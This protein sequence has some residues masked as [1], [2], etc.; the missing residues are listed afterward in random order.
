MAQILAF[1]M[2]STYTRLQRVGAPRHS[3]SSSDEEPSL[4]K[5]RQL[6]SAPQPASFGS[7]MTDSVSELAPEQI[8]TIRPS[9]P[10]PSSAEFELTHDRA[11]PLPF[12]I[13]LVIRGK[14]HACRYVGHGKSKVV[15]KLTDSSMVLKL[16]ANEDKEPYVSQQ[17]SS[18]CRAVQPELKICPAIYAIGRCQQ[19]D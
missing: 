6:Q 16:T 15:Y 17:L 2:Q 10:Q 14:T 1:I 19:Q 13:D 18:S 11:I 12:A 5:R 3:S 7:V 8:W 4:A 9:Y